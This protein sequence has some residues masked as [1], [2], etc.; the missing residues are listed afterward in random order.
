MKRKN[1]RRA[2]TNNALEANMIRI[3][4]SASAKLEIASVRSELLMFKSSCGPNG[5]A[6]EH[7]RGGIPNLLLLASLIIG[8]HSRLNF[9][10]ALMLRIRLPQMKLRCLGH[11]EKPAKA[12]PRR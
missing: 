12:R 7:L 9:I 6:S 8:Q 3:S 2:V 4:A 1:L 11:L 5:S 10:E